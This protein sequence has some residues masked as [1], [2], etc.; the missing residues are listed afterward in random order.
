[1]TEPRPNI[2]RSTPEPF[3]LLVT[4]GRDYFESFRVNQ[5]LGA[6][7]FLRPVGLLIVGDADGA[8]RLARE[9]AQQNKV[10][11]RE[12][13][14]DWNGQGRMAGPLRNA[15]MVAEGKPHF[16]VVFPGGAGTRDMTLRLI[17]ARV[18]MLFA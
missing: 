7:H 18:R 13:K 8:D 16:A 12:F 10:P 2:A 17:E 3:R 14:A 11:I 5:V 15:R 4:G 6:V 9:W 1:M